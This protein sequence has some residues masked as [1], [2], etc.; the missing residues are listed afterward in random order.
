MSLNL[1]KYKKPLALLSVI[2]LS[3][4]GG[5]S[6]G[7][8]SGSGTNPT[9]TPPAPTPPSVTKTGK[10]SDLTFVSANTAISLSNT[11]G[12]GYVVVQN[13]TNLPI[14][15]ISYTVNPLTGTKP[16]ATIL[17]NSPC[18]NIAANSDC[19]LNIQ[20]ESGVISGSFNI[21]AQNSESTLAN[22]KINSANLTAET[23][24]KQSL[25]IGIQQVKYHLST[26][27][28]NLFYPNL[29]LAGTS[30]VLI[31]GVVTANPTTGFNNVELVDANG[32]LIP[33]QKIISSNLG[34]GLTNLAI[35]QTFAILAPAPN[36][37]AASLTF[38]LRTSTLS[39]NRQESNVVISSLTN[40]ITTT[41]NN[42][43][44]VLSALT[45]TVYLTK[46]NPSQVITLANT[47][48][49]PILSLNL[50]SSDNN[51]NVRTNATTIN[52]ESAVNV[53]LSLESTTGTSTTNPVIINYNDSVSTRQ[54]AINIEQ[55]LTPTSTAAVAG[56]ITSFTPDY[57]FTKTSNGAAV[58]RH[59][60]LTN[61]G[62][63]VEDNITISDI[64]AG[65]TLTDGISTNPCHVINGNKIANLLTPDGETNTCDITI[66]FNSSAI[67][68]QT[69]G[70]LVINYNYN[71]LFQQNAT[72]IASLIY[73][74][75]PSL[76]N[77]VIS[78]TNS[79]Q[80]IIV[81]NNED[82]VITTYKLTNLGS[83]SATDLNVTIQP[84]VNSH[85]LFKL[86]P[87]PGA[88]RSTLAVGQSCNI[89]VAFG[90]ADG[91]IQAPDTENDNLIIS[92]VPYPGSNP[93]V[94]SRLLTGNVV[95]AQAAII[96]ATK[97]SASGFVDG[98]GT[99]VSPY[100][101]QENTSGYITYNITN[102][103][104]SAA[105]NFYIDTA[106]LSTGWSV[107]T[108]NCGTV[109]SP[110]TLAA[111]NGTCKVQFIILSDTIGP[112]DLDLGLVYA[113]WNDQLS[114]IYQAGTLLNGLTYIYVYSPA[115]IEVYKHYNNAWTLIDPNEELNVKQGEAMEI[116]PYIDGGY[117]LPDQTLL[118]STSPN[119]D[120]ITFENNPC[121]LNVNNY[122][123]N[124][125][126]KIDTSTA[127]GAHDI[128]IN[129]VSSSE[130][131]PNVNKIKI[132]VTPIHIIF[133]T[134]ESYNGNL[135]DGGGSTIVTPHTTGT[136]GAD[137]I[138]Q[139]E[140]YSSGST[141]PTGLT[142]KALLVD[143]DRYPC[144]ATGQCGGSHSLDW[145]LNQGDIYDNPADSSVS[146]STLFN[147]VNQNYVFDGSN[148]YLNF[149][150]GLTASDNSE[151]WSGIQSIHINELGNDI[152]GWAYAD[153]N[154]DFDG[155]M[156]TQYSPGTCQ[157]FTSTSSE[158]QN[159]PNSFGSFGKTSLFYS[160]VGNIAPSTWGNFYYF[161]NQNPTYYVLNIW[162]SSYA[163]SCIETSHLICVSQ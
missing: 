105:T 20:V 107:A 92:H 113:T 100:N 37:N 35:G 40:T 119:T 10:A 141:I 39:S 140:A 56:L 75:T 98:D 33:N 78:Q 77:V 30:N 26:D 135:K 126:T 123:C 114:P 90:P 85:N 13:K 121:T 97:D 145:V 89:A 158:P 136:A 53:T 5:G 157:N 23:S 82:L 25:P 31:T 130:I 137:A 28:I 3:S 36:G 55:G 131:T 80:N 71:S 99:E 51:V 70:S 17:G 150:N 67:T 111:L 24:Q 29:V 83:E 86:V 147:T 18:A 12:Q 143:A 108:S 15:G 66:T 129:N 64:P 151:F 68:S 43:Q 48:N 138:C 21:T 72:S 60:T 161:E 104:Q 120:S 8:S 93:T 116:I 14:V 95:N 132:N 124:V 1:S 134:S 117:N 127:L 109:N 46:D 142:F 102:T 45:Q 96:T 42:N 159:N 63:T 110:I 9:P 2:L 87:P 154:P 156:Y 122:Y 148:I 125:Y 160:A 133:M 47:G 32:N 34:A 61:S 88:C 106:N 81:N 58:I 162:S 7:S 146:N 73:E 22:N 57:I 41:A 38:K 16:N 152:D 6:G 62:N 163:K 4:C 144:D 74:V 112:N 115:K 69:V 149:A 50:V 52:P 91:T 59:L 65:F 76:A 103:G 118:F 101:I 54:S 155:A 84:G 27:D 94:D 128:L 139:S 19:V 49:Q 11:N 79:A 44:G 153:A